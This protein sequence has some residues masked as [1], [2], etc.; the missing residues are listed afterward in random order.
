MLG[1]H[2]LTIEPLVLLQS[3]S[4]TLM[5]LIYAAVAGPDA[6]WMTNERPV[7]SFCVRYH[8][9]RWHYKNNVYNNEEMKFYSHYKLVDCDI[10]L[11]VQ[12]I[13]CFREYYSD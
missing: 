5:L 2:S 4:A 7:C 8:R 13:A 3:D 12:Y 6:C 9:H 10:L 11:L 1:K